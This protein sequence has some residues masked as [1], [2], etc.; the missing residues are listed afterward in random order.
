MSIELNQ[1]DKIF[2]NTKCEDGRSNLIN[3]GEFNILYDKLINL[4]KLIL[5]SYEII[6]ENDLNILV[7]VLRSIRNSCAGCQAN[8]VEVQ[9]KNVI[10]IVS[11]I[12]KYIALRNITKKFNNKSDNNNNDNFND[13]NDEENK[14]ILKILSD[15]TL[16]SAQI[17]ANFSAC[18]MDQCIYIWTNK[19]K[20]TNSSNKD[21]EIFLYDCIRDIIAASLTIRNR[22]AIAA[23][24]ASIYY[25][26]LCSKLI[27]SFTLNYRII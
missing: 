24:F 12:C 9:N 26:L 3:S 2:T 13:D 18:G 15:I 11:R 8:A 21:K 7:V 1:F 10:Y 16:V 6:T 17:I 23:I 27:F 19:C 25:S 14:D 4:E 20:I 5:N 22:K